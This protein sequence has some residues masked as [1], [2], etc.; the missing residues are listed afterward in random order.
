MYKAQN[1]MIL[2]KE[3]LFNHKIKVSIIER[4]VRLMIF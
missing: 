1:Y 3:G 4:Q 2:I